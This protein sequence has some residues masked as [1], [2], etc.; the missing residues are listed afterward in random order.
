MKK[1]LFTF[2]EKK[3]CGIEFISAN[4]TEEAWENLAKVVDDIS[5]WEMQGG[6]E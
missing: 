3:D 5:E 4:S 2:R 6:I 1:I